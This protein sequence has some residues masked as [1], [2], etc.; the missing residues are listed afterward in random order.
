MKCI[1]LFAGIGGS[2]E[3]ARQAGLQVVWAANHNPEAVHYHKLN[4][5]ETTHACQDLQQADF[6]RVPAH[7]LLMASP[8]C[9]GHSA[10]RGVDRPHH[11]VQRATAWAVVTAAEVHRPRL[12]VVENVEGFQRWQLFP[13]WR[14]ALERLGYHLTINLLDAAD[15][16]VPQH[17]VRLF[18]T[19]RLGQALPPVQASAHGI[20]VPASSFIDLKSGS[21]SQIDRP[22]RAQ[23]TLERVARGRAQ[24]G[25][26]FLMPYYSKGSGLTGRSIDRPVG[27]I[28]TRSRWALVHGDRMR[29]LTVQ[30]NRK[31]MGF[32]DHYILPPSGTK[33]IH[34]L[35][36]AVPPPMMREI[37]NQLKHHV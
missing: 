19:G 25:P 13:V 32:P 29:M 34:Q 12:L 8:A 37:L 3:G 10:A 9:Q 11:D 21:W 18:V 5:P 24:F 27:T 30:E 15:F 22:G 7:D 17:R 14:Q 2:S 26:T 35:G 4:H 16:G 20:H 31:A 36:N 6:T 1:D 33:A 23:P 28:T